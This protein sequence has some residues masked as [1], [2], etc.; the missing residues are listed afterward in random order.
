M[1][2]KVIAAVINC[3][4]QSALDLAQM[5]I[6]LPTQN[7]QI[8]RI[9]RFEGKNSRW[10]QIRRRIFG[11]QKVDVQRFSSRLFHYG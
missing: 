5:A 6:Q 2:L 3:D 1:Q 11:R 9:I 7:R 8:T 10:C 4:A